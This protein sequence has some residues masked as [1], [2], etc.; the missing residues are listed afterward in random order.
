MSPSML[1]RLSA[2]RAP[3][4]VLAGKFSSGSLAGRRFIRTRAVQQRWIL[5]HGFYIPIQT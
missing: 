2:S 5:E 3:E 4:V 1:I